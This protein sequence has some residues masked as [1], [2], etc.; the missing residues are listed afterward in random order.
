MNILYTILSCSLPE[1]SIV[2]C[3]QSRNLLPLFTFSSD[4]QLFRDHMTKKMLEMVM[5][6]EWATSEINIRVEVAQKFFIYYA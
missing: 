5:I 1:K 4:F 2:K 3:F 6:D